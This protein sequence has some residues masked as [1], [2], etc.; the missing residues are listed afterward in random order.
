MLEVDQVHEIKKLF[1]RGLSI[2]QIVK[3][4]GF[5]RNTVR[6]YLRG[7]GVPGVYQLKEPKPQPVIGTVAGVVTELLVAE[8]EAHTP[9]RY[10]RTVFRANPVSFTI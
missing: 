6:R 9:R 4:T 10:R 1:G 7:K 3:Q 5:A 8:K 2:H